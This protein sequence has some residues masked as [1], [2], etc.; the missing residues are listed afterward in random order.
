MGGTGLKS[1]KQM[2]YGQSILSKWVRGGFGWVLFVSSLLLLFF[3]LCCFYFSELGGVKPPMS[4]ENRSVAN[5]FFLCCLWGNMGPA[6]AVGGL[7]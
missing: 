4:L 5:P 2:G 1:S 3:L 6:G 7:T